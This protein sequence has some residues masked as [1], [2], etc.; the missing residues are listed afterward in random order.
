MGNEIQELR[1]YK[2]RFYEA[3]GSCGP[4]SGTLSK[5]LSS[6]LHLARHIFKK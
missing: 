4:Y 6:K 2:N 5:D 3:I 1:S